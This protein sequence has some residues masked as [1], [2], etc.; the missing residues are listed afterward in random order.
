MIV[1][2]RQTAVIVIGYLQQQ[3]T[4]WNESKLKVDQLNKQRMI[5]RHCN[6][7][8]RKTEAQCTEITREGNVGK[9]YTAE[10]NHARQD[11]GSKTKHSTHKMKDGIK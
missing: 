9:A 6:K 7:E 2:T 10:T 3:K 5:N 11:N 4:K 1:K 8:L